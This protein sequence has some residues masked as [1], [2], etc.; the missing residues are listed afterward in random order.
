M[1]EITS[2]RAVLLALSASAAL[3]LSGCAAGDAGDT[4]A[5]ES[6]ATETVTVTAPPQSDARVAGAPAVAGDDDRDDRD[7]DD[8]DDWE[9]DRDGRDDDD[10]DDDRADRDDDRDDDDN[11]LDD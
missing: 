11:D 8:D 4:P 7:D 1:T 5:D 9:D 2:P 6:P 3:L 10:H